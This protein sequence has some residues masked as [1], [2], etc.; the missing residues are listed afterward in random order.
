M[1]RWLSVLVVG[2]SCVGIAGCG[3]DAV[4]DVRQD[5]REQAEALRDRVD[6]EIGDRAERVR[7]RLREV[8]SEARR[9]GRDLERRVRQALED[10]ERTVP[11]AGPA[12]RP[13]STEGREEEG[14]IGAFLTDTLRS[15]DRY[16]TRTFEANGQREPRVSYVW[17]PQGRVTRS[18]CGSPADDTA[19][20]Y[21]PADDTIY[22]GEVLAAGVFEGVA[23]GF[24]GQ[25][26]GYGRAVGDFGTAYLVA[27][28]YAHNLQEELGFFSAQRRGASARPFELQADCL[29]GVWGAS[30]YREG[31]LK[32]GD[33]EE[34]LNT[35]LAVG[36]FEVGSEQHHGTPEE[37]RDAWQLGFDSG[38]PS[39]CTAFVRA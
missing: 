25:Q 7:T 20:F 32:P 39:T 23:D 24:P 22:V 6:R 27:H 26:A 21:C 16:W 13:P 3:S 10:L 36:D 38:E 5:V 34:A 4:D 17:V 14:T 2:L 9:V 29:A 11:R 1:R 19:A 12:T 31:R 37:R 35:A 15:V 33:V 18:G 28:E 30:V 8:R